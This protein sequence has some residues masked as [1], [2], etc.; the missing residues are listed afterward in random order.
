M[1]RIKILLVDD[2]EENLLSLESV[3][4]DS[5][6][7]LIKAKSG[8]E[9]LAQV[10]KNDFAVILMDVKMPDMDGFET[11]A[12]IKQRDKSRSIPIIFMT[13][14]SIDEKN[15]SA[16][17]SVGAVDYVLKPFDPYILKSKVHVF[18]D[19]YKKNRQLQKQTDM[20]K[21][22]EARE[23][24]R[25]LRDLESE[26]K[27]RY[28]NLA[29]ALPQI[30]FRTNSN[31][32]LEYMNQHWTKYTGKAVQDSLGDQWQSL[33]FP[34]DLPIIFKNWDK[35]IETKK[36]FHQEL[37]LCQND[38]VYRWHI[39]RVVP[40]YDSAL[41]LQSWIGSVND[42]HDQ[43]LAQEELI[44]S[45]IQAEVANQT[46]SNFLANMSHEIR[47]P[48][49]VI[50]GYS[51]ILIDSK[52]SQIDKQNAFRAIKQNGSQLSKIIDEILDLSKVE[53]GKM[54]FE[55]N[56]F[57][58]VNFLGCL[59]SFFTLSAKNKGLNLNFKTTNSIPEK[60]TAS[61]SRI[62]Q[63]MVNLVGNAIKFSNSGD[64]TVTCEYFDSRGKP[65]IRFSVKDCGPGLSSDQIKNLFQP[66]TQADTSIT[67]KHG[68]TGLGLALSRKLAHGM[69]GEITILESKTGEGCNFELSLP[70]KIKKETKFV[71]RIESEQNEVSLSET[72]PHSLKGIKVLLVEDSID[73][74]ELFTLFLTAAGAQVE[75]ANNG[76]EGV[77]KAQ[78][79]EHDVV[80]MDIQMPE[81]DGYESIAQLRTQEYAKPII[82]LTAHGMVED[83]Q[84][85]FALGA[86]GH[87]TKPIDRL[88]LINKVRYYGRS[89]LVDK[90]P[91][92]DLNQ[93]L[94]E[95]PI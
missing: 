43:K 53:A 66:F 37:R 62:H 42:I 13:A 3:L 29:D 15:I 21:E 92:S 75:I 67:R 14:D 16:G 69:N 48:L 19:L 87:L 59:K 74:Q 77:K 81:L 12:I 24:F 4:D 36:G 2:R 38:G 46:K 11:T 72:S 84:R 32:D 30:I 10:F 33:I 49:G 20:L 85:C 65:Y 61:Q 68:G 41:N 39:M 88:T 17:Y 7:H 76:L 73:N 27:R 34:D 58:L 8:Q 23:R 64:I 63:I 83:R 86:D 91:Y 25:I 45:K 40:E 35:A 94:N 1:D 5:Q 51:E 28:Q 6:Y 22:I 93:S 56:E 50:L 78:T 79:G 18:A 57:S 55:E 89:A 90:S 70:I 44:H 52:M 26:S 47:T 60:I 31:G 82:A 95:K 71:D 9:A 80:L 54:I